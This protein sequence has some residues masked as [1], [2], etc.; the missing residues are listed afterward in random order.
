MNIAI[1]GDHRAFKH[2]EAINKFLVK[3][4]HQV[5]DY[6]CYSEESADY[7]D[8]ALSVAQ[9]VAEGMSEK[10][11]LICATGI[12]MSIAAN[13]IPKI[14]AAVC[15]DKQTIVASREHNNANVLCLGTNYLKIPDME[16]HILVWLSTTFS[17]DRHTKRLDK[18]V[19]I[20]YKYMKEEFMG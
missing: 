6:G 3:A 17:G 16:E 7:P 1:G 18:I 11:I 14:R 2:K 15:W 8:F 13:K 12:G 9:A 10:G 20:E 4:G 5:V 19:Q